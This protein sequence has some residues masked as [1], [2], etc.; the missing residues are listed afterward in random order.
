MPKPPAQ[1]PATPMTNKSPSVE[2]KAPA[3]PPTATS[4]APPAA[5]GQLPPPPHPLTK[6]LLP[7]LQPGEKG[8]KCLVLDLDETLVHSSF[9]PIPNPDFV[10]SI[11]LENIIHKVYVR[12]RPGVDNFMRVVGEKFEVV[13]FTA[14]LA[15]YADPLLDILDRNKVVKVRLFREACVQHYGNYVKD[16]THLGRPLEHTLII[17]NSPFSYMFQPD[18]AI[19]ISSWFNDRNDRQL[20]DLLPFLDTIAACDD[21]VT[22]LQKHKLTFNS[23]PP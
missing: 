4:S 12:K 2:R 16:L 3:N 18:N 11:E 22:V 13:I 20:Y 15:K 23:A 6:Y 10:I 9:K 1:P 5:P 17:D 14:S 21:V 8:K 7:P 19:P